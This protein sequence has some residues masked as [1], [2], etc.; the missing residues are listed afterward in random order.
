MVVAALGGK[1]GFMGNNALRVLCGCNAINWVGI[2]SNEH[3][4]DQ[5]VPTGDCVECGEIA[6]LGACY[7]DGVFRPICVDCFV[8][9]CI[10]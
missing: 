2:M 5:R 1:G 8:G 10:A 3:E 9:G 6:H 4:R 7:P